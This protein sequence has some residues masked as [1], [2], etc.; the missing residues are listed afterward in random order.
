MRILRL[1]FYSLV[2]VLMLLFLKTPS[3]AAATSNSVNHPRILF[4]PQFLSK[5]Q[6]K[7]R[8]NDPTWIKLKSQCDTYL[9]G[10]IEYPDGKDYGGRES[11]GEGYQ[12]S[13]YFEALMNLGVCYQVT[14]AQ[15]G[16]E[17]SEYAKKGVDV[18]VKMSVPEGKE[19]YQNPLRDSGYGIR[20]FGVGMA[21]GYDWFYDRMTETEKKQVYSSLNHWIRTYE[22]KG[23][24][25]EHPQ[26]NYFAGYYAAKALAALATEGDN[27]E[28]DE[29]LDEW[30]NKQHYGFVQPYYSQWMRGG[31]WPEGWNYGPLGSLNMTWPIIAAYSAKN[32]NLLY[33]PA[34]SFTFPE[35]Q[36]TNLIHFSWPNRKTLDDRGALY[37][38]DNPAQT[39]SDLATTLSGMLQFLNSDKASLLKTFAQEVRSSNGGA[40]V[41]Q[42]FLFWDD[43]ASGQEY[44]DLPLSYVASGMNQIA[45][46]SSWDTSAVWAS[47]SS[48][49]Y[50]NYPGSGEQFYDQGG[51]AIVKGD[52]PVL[53][54]ATGALLRNKVAGKSDAN[55]GEAIYEDNYGTK[56]R[57]LFN[58][59]YAGKGQIPKTPNLL[60]LNDAP[61][62]RLTQ[63]EDQGNYV[64]FR[65]IHLEEMYRDN[66][67]SLW[68]REVIYF[69]P[70]IFV[71]ADNTL[72]PN[73]QADQ[74]QAFHLTYKPI[75]VNHSQ[76]HKVEIRQNDNYLGSVTSLYPVNHT[77]KLTS[78][79]NSDKVYRLEIRPGDRS[80]QQI[81]L[82]AFEL[83]IHPNNTQIER[84]SLKVNNN[85]IFGAL[86]K[87]GQRNYVAVFSTNQTVQQTG[88]ISYQIPSQK[89][90]HV[91]S[92]LPEGKYAV[93][94]QEKSGEAVVTIKPGGELQTTKE[95]RLYFGTEGTNVIGN[96]PADYKSNVAL[97][98]FESLVN[99]ENSLKTE[100]VP[101]L[102][103]DS[104]EKIPLY[105]LWNKTTRSEFY[106][107]SSQEKNALLKN[108]RVWED[109]GTAQ[110]VVPLSQC[111]TEEG[112]VPVRLFAS[113]YGGRY[114]YTKSGGEKRF[115]TQ[116]NSAR[117]WKDRG[118]VFCVY[119]NEREGTLPVYRFRNL[120]TSQYIYALGEEEKNKLSKISPWRL[121]GVSFYAFQP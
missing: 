4:T 15:G 41:W 114:I 27:A 65:G 24:G 50:T 115:L 52:T 68:N 77:T 96:P 57:T 120:R 44:R 80:V 12:G 30:L 62:T 116:K 87:Q 21:L 8:K 13:G 16:E 39:N 59:F 121:E 67:V 2:V 43:T 55:Y 6:D 36:V 54:N 11:I 32:I 17:A 29:M 108:K 22:Q 23:F 18:L 47:F 40:Q 83:G 103:V 91:V 102:R 76:G 99:N 1:F 71:I 45:V 64:A 107:V 81:W 26:G 60:N 101:V 100:D 37:A 53:V 113:T 5:L 74:Y 46:R 66:T 7:V 117:I 31:G 104:V 38:G 97:T 89:T 85:Q 119:K 84:L 63:V 42:E 98:N 10:K 58:V 118:E 33:D 73:S 109:K 28:A 3:Q 111:N 93:D 110:Q 75:E 106:T 14:K 9:K 79:F 49:P 90:I 72:V 34:R 35:E 51:L 20:F 48:G 70:D 19:H 86:I 25:R 112:L 56:N 69:R 92:G 94:V 61:K 78:V 88:E 105:R 95:G 82:T